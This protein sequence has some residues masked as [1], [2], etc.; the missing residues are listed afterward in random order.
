V[1]DGESEL[2]RV[3]REEE[4]GFWVAPDDVEAV[5]EAMRALRGNKARLE[6]C[7]RNGE[8]FAA[9]FEEGRVLGDFEEVL[10]EL[11]EGEAR[12]SEAAV[13]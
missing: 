5:A 3:V 8:R 10:K 2:A 4:L 9:R 11:A 7:A 12:E 13:I 6:E 1:T